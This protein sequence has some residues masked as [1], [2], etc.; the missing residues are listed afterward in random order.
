MTNLKAALN[1]CNGLVF[2]SQ[3]RRG[4]HN[5]EKWECG[6]WRY[7]STENGIW[8][9]CATAL[10]EEAV[11]INFLFCSAV[12]WSSINNEINGILIGPYS[13]QRTVGTFS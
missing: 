8:V 1:T 13:F 12:T 3:L 5:E 11:G 2:C 7:C 9:D 10:K 4:F 6:T